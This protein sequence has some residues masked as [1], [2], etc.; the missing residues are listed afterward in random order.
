M[1]NQIGESISWNRSFQFIHNQIKSS[2]LQ[3]FG[4]QK[5]TTYQ[6]TFILVHVVCRRYKCKFPTNF[7]CQWARKKIKLWATELDT[8]IRFPV[9]VQPKGQLI[10]EWN[11]GV[12]K[13]PKKPTKFL[14]DFCPSFIG[15]K[16]V[17]NLVGFLGDLKTPKNSFWD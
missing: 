13:S 14:T 1:Y 6:Y 10:S 15:Q 7:S 8:D 11:F 17:Q 3:H 12:F 9:N 16:S 5:K 2:M 4:F